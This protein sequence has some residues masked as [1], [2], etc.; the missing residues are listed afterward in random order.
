M[1]SWDR[2]VSS[3]GIW[4]NEGAENESERWKGVFKK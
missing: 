2:D 3:G 1:T 4:D